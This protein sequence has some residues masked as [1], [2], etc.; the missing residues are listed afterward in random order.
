MLAH[1]YVFGGVGPAYGDGE[2]EHPKK[3]G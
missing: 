3:K 1:R 2:L